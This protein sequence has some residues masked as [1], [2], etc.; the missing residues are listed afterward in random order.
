MNAILTVDGV[1]I[2]KTGPFMCMHPYAFRDM[3]GEE[4]YQKL[5][6]GPRAPYPQWIFGPKDDDDDF[7]PAA[8]D[9]TS[10]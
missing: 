5:I 4:E 2:T 9:K 1:V 7:E 8:G 3:F 10:T 6:A